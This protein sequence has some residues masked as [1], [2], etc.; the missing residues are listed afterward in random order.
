MKQRQ[1]R[2]FA[3]TLPGLEAVCADELTRLGVGCVN[4]VAGGVEFE[5]G[6]RE[7]YLANLWVRTATRILVRV[8]EVQARDFP[9]L[10]RKL[11]KLPWGRFL[12]PGCRFEVRAKC[13]RSRLVHSDRVAETV[14]DAID[15]ALGD[16]AQTDAEP[17]LVFVRLEDD[18]CQLSVDSSGPLL[19][20]RGYRQQ[21]VAAPLRETLAAG[22]LLSLGWDGSKGLVD[23]MTGSGT[24]AIEAALIAGRRAPGRQRRFAFM[25]WPRYRDGL[26]QAL[27]KEADRERVDVVNVPIC[28]VDLNPQA[29]NAA[30]ENASRA[31][32]AEMIDFSVR[33]MQELTAP[34]ADGLILCNPPYGERLGRGEELAGLYGDLGHLYQKQFATWQAALL[35]PRESLARAT[36]L[37]WNTC[38]QFS[39][40]GLKISLLQRKQARH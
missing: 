26:W 10:Y 8:G 4:P 24:F 27:L 32:V 14:S 35:S 28:G 2:Y 25:D 17:Q 31:G 30:K 12:K 39:N 37:K 22:I 21:A 18:Q 38:F 11:V 23:A 19:H 13:R 40:G 33:P 7:L 5:G 29:I 6:L 1:D 9:G 16:F 36:W 3:V 34:A 15:K 20:R